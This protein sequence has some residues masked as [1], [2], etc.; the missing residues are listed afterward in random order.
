MQQ[1]RSQS[2]HVVCIGCGAPDK[3]MGWFHLTQLLQESRVRVQSVVEPWFLGPSCKDD[4]P[5][6]RAFQA[7]QESVVHEHPEISF[8]AAIED[9]PNPGTELGDAAAPILAVFATRTNLLKDSF[10]AACNKGITHAY[11]EKPGAGTAEQ[12][13]EIQETA[14]RNNV[15]VMVGYNK[16][17]S[18][19]VQ[20]ALEEFRRHPVRLVTLE[21]NNPFEPDSRELKDFS[22]G[23]GNEGLVHNM[24]C[25]ELATAALYFGMSCSCI[26][27]LTL[28][29]KR[30]KVFSNAHGTRDWQQLA[31]RVSLAGSALE[32]EFFANRCGGDFSC[33][34]L[35]DEDESNNNGKRNRHSSFRLPS[36]SHEQWMMEVR[37]KSPNIRGYFLLQAPDYRRLKNKYVDHI[38]SRR[39]GVPSGGV[40]I[41]VALE[42]LRLADFIAP[43][44]DKLWDGAAPW[45]WT[46]EDRCSTAAVDKSKKQSY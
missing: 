32:L 37:A 18:D 7:F 30:S 3:G 36:E 22:A 28:D 31:F 13:K 1:E 8:V 26:S 34:H 20:D 19:Y 35:A 25:H 15:C 2:L 33:L 12:M 6:L 38:L 23:P 9:L 46:P 39:Q 27:S 4:S 44:V 10:V 45:R 17:V 5:D 11:L 14:C 41:P 42:V 29:T 40:D 43:T 16:C 24:L 21:H